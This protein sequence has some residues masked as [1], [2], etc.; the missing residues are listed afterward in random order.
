M[1]TK[2]HTANTFNANR[3]VETVI[4]IGAITLLLILF[5]Y[6]NAFSNTMQLEE[7]Q[8]I[9][10]TPFDTELV[11]NEMM[12]PEFYFKDEAYIDDI[13][14]NTACVSANCNYIKAVSLIFEMEDET[15]IE[16]M[17]FN[18]EKVTERYLFNNAVLLNFQLSD[19]AYIDDIPFNTLNIA[20][21]YYKA[22]TTMLYV[23]E[24]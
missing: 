7:E 12:T 10:D 1:K 4:W 6:T 21:C 17:P 3:T 8:Y 14:F 20:N 19:E 5:S 18:T 13:P 2:L 11:V 24:M 23:S 22:D 9:D 15:F 16:D